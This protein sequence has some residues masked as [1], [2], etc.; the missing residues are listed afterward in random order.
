M[1]REG[2]NVME[3]EPDS[4]TM[5]YGLTSITLS[6]EMVNYTSRQFRTFCQVFKAFLMT[7]FPPEVLDGYWNIKDSDAGAQ[8][9]SNSR[10]IESTDDPVRI[11]EKMFC[12]ASSQ[13]GLMIHPLLKLDN[14]PLFLS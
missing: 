11:I 1:P 3:V 12:D 14:R 7:T 13:D 6:G 4:S 9:F 10:S 5:C 8:T 2:D